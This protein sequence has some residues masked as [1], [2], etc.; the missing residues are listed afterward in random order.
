MDYDYHGGLH[1][2]AE[3]Y[4][5]TEHTSCRTL[6]S[7][8][9]ALFEQANLLSFDTDLQLFLKENGVIF[10]APTPFSFVPYGDDVVREYVTSCVAVIEVPSC[11]RRRS[12]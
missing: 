5:E 9:D 10:T 6:M 1:R 8:A 4:R 12:N 2:I 11:R 7:G 3:S